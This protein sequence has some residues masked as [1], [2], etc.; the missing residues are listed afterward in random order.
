MSTSDEKDPYELLREAVRTAR[1]NAGRASGDHRDFVRL[2]MRYTSTVGALLGVGLL[3]LPVEPELDQGAWLVS[4]AFQALGDGG[5]DSLAGL[6]FLVMVIS[7]AISIVTTLSLGWGDESQRVGFISRTAPIVFA[8]C[9]GGLSLLLLGLYATGEGGSWMAPASL[10]A[11]ALMLF[12]MSCARQL[13]AS[14]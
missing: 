1:L 11:A 2:V 10:M 4:A 13:E 12:T 5:A 9:A 14:S 7:L 3:L 8:V 6:A